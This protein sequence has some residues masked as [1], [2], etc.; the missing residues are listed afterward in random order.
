MRIGIAKL[1][2]VKLFLD[3]HASLD[4]DQK[5]DGC[6]SIIFGKLVA[7]DRSRT[8]RIGP[9][10]THVSDCSDCDARMAYVP[11]KHHQHATLRPV[12]DGTN[13][14]YPRIVSEDRSSIYAALEGQN[15]SIPVGFIPQENVTFA[16]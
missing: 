3:I 10:T 12:F 1:V 2:L 5:R 4:Y 9:V 8:R 6:T 14:L 11:R 7:Y 15:S 16:L 13:S